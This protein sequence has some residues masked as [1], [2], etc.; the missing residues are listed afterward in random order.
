M[1]FMLS[2]ELLRL[3][4]T[5]RRFV[6]EKLQPLE[7]EV[8]LADGHLDPK[9]RKELE[10]IAMS[11]G[12]HASSLPKS[13]G[14]TGYSWEAQ[15]VINEEIGAVTYGLGWI[16][17]APAIVLRHAS[18]DQVERWV[19]PATAGDRVACYA[20]TEEN[21]GSD[22]SR[23]STTARRDGEDWIIS[24]EKW[25]VTSGDVAD[26]AVVQ[27]GTDPEVGDGNTLFFVDLES[28][29]I[30]EIEHPKYTHNLIDGHP[31][32]AFR[33]VRVS[34]ANRFG[35][36]GEG[37][38]ISKEWFLHERTMIAAR[39]LGAARR[40]ISEASDFAQHRVQFGECISEYQMIQQML[41]DSASELWAARLMTFATA[42][43]MDLARSEEDRK[44]VHTKASMTKL[45]AAE[46]ANRVADRAVQIF[47]GRGYMR[48]N[49]AERFF[50]ELRVE[51]IWEGSS[52]IQRVIIAY[53]LYKRGIEALVG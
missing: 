32:F 8:E 26:F 52:E 49:V 10:G 46:M 35:P 45:Y 14:G 50:R 18:P 20:V 21:A 12:I 42:R 25:H 43:A 15:I 33:G 9:R 3:Q 31:K 13:V 36:V 16:V 48:E 24:G 30:E 2:P 41:A 47:G 22:A 27:C 40:L 5:V 17:F 29:G 19:R 53:S 37:L 28:P 23:M 39:C 11:L 34:D 38:T 51:R 44:L 4:E 1:D 6:V 7:V